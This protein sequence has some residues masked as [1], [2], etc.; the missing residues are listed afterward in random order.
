[1]REKSND[2]HQRFCFFSGSRKVYEQIQEGRRE[3]KKRM[4]REDKGTHLLAASLLFVSHEAH[5][6]I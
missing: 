3:E 5:G 6:L 4:K 1:L 2:R